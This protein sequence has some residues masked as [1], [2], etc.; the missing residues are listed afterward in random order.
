[1]AYRDYVA[2]GVNVFVER[3]ESQ[4]VVN[5]DQF[6]PV[7]VGTGST[8][9][10]R[11]LTFSDITADTSAFPV[12]TLNISFRNLI[13]QQ[14]YSETTFTISSLK[15]QQVSGSTVTEVT[16]T[17][18]TDYTVQSVASSVSE[19]GDTTVVVSILKDGVS[20]TDTVYDLTLSAQNTD[21]DFDLRLVES[22]DSFDSLQIF[23]PLYLTE[24][25]N[26]IRNDIAFA[27]E[28]AFRM[29]VPYFYYLEVPRTYGSAATASEIVDNLEK[30]FFKKNAYRIVPLSSDSTVI[31]AVKDL[32]EAISNPYD[33][34]ETAGF[35]SYDTSGISDINNVSG[36]LTT[37]GELSVTL[38]SARVCNVFAGKTLELVVSGT[39]YTLPHFYA[40]VAVACLD[41][42]V[43]LADPLSLREITIFKKLN[44][45]KLRPR[46]WNELAKK[47][48]FIMYQNDTT[49]PII[50]RHQLTTSQSDAAEDQEYSLVKNIDVLTRLFRD[51]LASYAGKFNITD[52]LLEKLDATMITAIS[53]AKT[54]GL[55]RDITVQSPWS[56]RR[57][58][59]DANNTEEKRNLVI[60][61]KV[62]PAYPANNLDIYLMI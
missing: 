12:V 42:G 50:I 36:L 48:V 1:M 6:Y 31:S 29:N 41:S 22:A 14:L 5:F 11:T 16:L 39:T 3:Q 17:P 28:I 7:F 26:T 38:N 23:G 54:I 60:R 30:V 15:V 37:V 4:A 33:K 9:S 44:G 20:D 19:N 13:N 56:V 40:S 18:V 62:S 43:G 45:P 35:V 49:E 25:G 52:G 27:A 21:E 57:L 58:P 24:N 51:R 32:V 34:R 8:S 2:P 59:T 10:Q 53:E 55:V 46:Q 47:R 61:L